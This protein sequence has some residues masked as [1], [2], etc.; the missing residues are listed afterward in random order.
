MRLRPETITRQLL[1]IETA[2]GMPPEAAELSTRLFIEASRD[3][4]ASHGLN[5]FP[6]FIEMI[7]AGLVDPVAR[8]ERLSSAG[9]IERWTGNLGPG[10]VNAH[11]AMAAAVSL[12]KEHGVG[13]VAM[14]RTNHWMRGGAYGQQAADAG[15]IGICWTN[16]MPNLPPW[17]STKQLI[18]NNPFI[19]AVPSLPGGHVVLDMAM[20]QFSYGAL[21]R[22]ASRGEELPT[23]GGFDEAGKPTRDAAA[24]KRTGRLLPTGSWKGSG[25][26]LLL[27]MTA[28]LLSGGAATHEIASDPLCESGVS[29]VFIA[30]D[31]IRFR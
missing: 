9:A 24:I 20:S 21:S 8:A 10:N 14:G 6:R 29:Q 13:V 4:V 22:Y 31:V 26:A 27:D 19:I 15:C 17:G 11:D 23:V 30:F 25:M 28:A 16:T 12:A 3:G 2:F 18:G 5:R 1:E 7:R